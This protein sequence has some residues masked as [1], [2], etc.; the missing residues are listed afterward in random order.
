MNSDEFLGL[1]RA[2]HLML[3]TLDKKLF[4][5]SPKS[6]LVANNY[7]SRDEFLQ[8]LQIEEDTSKAEIQQKIY[9]AESHLNNL[10][11]PCLS[12]ARDVSHAYVLARSTLPSVLDAQLVEL[13]ED[14]VALTRRFLLPPPT[15]KKEV[16]LFVITPKEMVKE[17]QHRV[18]CAK[19]FQLRLVFQMLGNIF[20]TTNNNSCWELIISLTPISHISL[21]LEVSASF[22]SYNLYDYLRFMERS[23]YSDTIKVAEVFVRDYLSKLVCSWHAHLHADT[24]SIVLSYFDNQDCLRFVVE[25]CESLW[26]LPRREHALARMKALATNAHEEC[27]INRF[28]TEVGFDRNNGPPLSYFSFQ[29]LHAF[30]SI[31]VQKSCNMDAFFRKCS[32]SELATLFG[33]E[34]RVC[35]KFVRLEDQKKKP[36]LGAVLRFQQF[37]EKQKKAAE[38]WKAEKQAREQI[39]STTK[40][41]LLAEKRLLQNM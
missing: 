21:M 2:L 23:A 26:A 10:R 40:S 19:L 5:P 11:I 12:E 37:L 39:Q 13:Q 4:G 24:A 38:N 28:L 33:L 18:D 20:K 22:I 30:T 27:S 31:S 3:I 41:L 8:A 35:R 7:L 16:D 36:T 9:D 29:V 14:Q 6:R 15:P 25:Q 17:N 1:L 34:E 32:P